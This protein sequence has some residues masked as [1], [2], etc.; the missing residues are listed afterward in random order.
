MG[1]PAV[2]LSISLWIASI[3][4]G[5]FFPQ[6][7][8]LHRRPALGPPQHPE[9]IV[10][11]APWLPCVDPDEEVP[12]SGDLHPSGAIPNRHTTAVVVRRECWR[13][14]QSPPEVHRKRDRD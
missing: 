12:R 11:V 13:T 14:G 1:S 8:A 3:T 6:A 4:S 9:P 10:A 2:S 5:V 7:Y